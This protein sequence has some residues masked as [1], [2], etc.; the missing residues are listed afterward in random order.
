MAWA[1][2]RMAKLSVN[3]RVVEVSVDPDPP[4]L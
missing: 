2:P 3:G 4:L 1:E